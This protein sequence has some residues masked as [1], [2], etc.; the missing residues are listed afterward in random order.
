MKQGPGI[1][2]TLEDGKRAE[3]VQAWLAARGL[4]A[5][6]IAD[7][8]AFKVGAVAGEQAL[9]LANALYESGLV[10]YAQP[11]WVMEVDRR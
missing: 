9:D 7:G 10:H 2:F 4:H 3:R 1:L 11:N 5:E 8:T 6:P